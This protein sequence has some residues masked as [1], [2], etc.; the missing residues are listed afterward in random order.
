MRCPVCKIRRT[1]RVQLVYGAPLTTVDA[2]LYQR[3][4]PGNPEYISPR[5]LLCYD[6]A[7]KKLERR[8]N[9]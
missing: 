9:K 6:K 1:M 4:Y 7:M 3:S 5:C 8:L 2:E